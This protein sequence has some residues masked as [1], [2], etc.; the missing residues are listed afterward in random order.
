MEV[1]SLNPLI[2]DRIGLLYTYRNENGRQL[3]GFIPSAAPFSGDLS[4]W[5]DVFDRISDILDDED[6]LISLRVC[7]TRE[8]YNLALQS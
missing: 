2:S 6:R 5:L 8:F 3:S 7:S 4:S 1:I